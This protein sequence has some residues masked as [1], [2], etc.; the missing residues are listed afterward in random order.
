MPFSVVLLQASINGAMPKPII[1][2]WDY[3]LPVS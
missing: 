3:V 2:P 1:T